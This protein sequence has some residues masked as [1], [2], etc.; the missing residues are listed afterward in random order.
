MDFIGIRVHA[1]SI[2]PHPQELQTATCK[3]CHYYGLVWVNRN[4]KWR[5]ETPNQSLHLCKARKEFDRS[6]RRQTT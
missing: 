4:N 2:P 6:R 3:H 1:P 5:L